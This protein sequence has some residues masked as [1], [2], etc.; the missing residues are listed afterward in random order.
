[1][2]M[3]TVLPLNDTGS[4]ALAAAAK[5]AVAPI[6]RTELINDRLIVVSLFVIDCFF[7]WINSS[8]YNP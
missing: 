8:D 2:I 6:A 1:M 4:A 7:L 5:T 3:V